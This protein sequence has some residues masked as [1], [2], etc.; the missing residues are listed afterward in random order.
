MHNYTLSKA[1]IHVNMMHVV[2]EASDVAMVNTE[3]DH[4]YKL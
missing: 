2:E 3:K 4:D 1:S